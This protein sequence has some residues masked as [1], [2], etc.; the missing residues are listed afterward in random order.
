ADDQKNIQG[1][2]IVVSTERSGRK[3]DNLTNHQL[4]FEGN[5]FNVKDDKGK[6]LFSGTFALDAGKKPPQIDM[7]IG[8]AGDTDK[9]VIGKVSEGLYQLDGDQLTWCSLPPGKGRP[10]EFAT[11]QDNENM[12]MM[13]KRKK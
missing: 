3:L 13:L 9:E 8:T 12:L 10:A 4:T 6:E 7:K 2:W 5:K 1:T 11:K